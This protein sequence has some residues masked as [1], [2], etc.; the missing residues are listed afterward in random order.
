MEKATNNKL[1]VVT[2]AT[3]GIGQQIVLQLAKN[4]WNVLMINR[5]EDK[6]MALRKKIE[7]DY[8]EVEVNYLIC[9]L[10]SSAEINST[11]KAIAEKELAISALINTAGIL[12][13]EE[14]ISLTGND[15]HFQINVLA[16][17][18]LMHGLR[19]SLKRSVQQGENAIIINVSSDA[20]FMSKPLAP[21]L[22]KRPKK[23][24]VFASYAN[25]KMALTVLSTYVAQD[26]E[27]DGIDVFAINP[28]GN[29]TAMTSGKSAPF[30]VRWFN[31]LGLLP[32]PSKGA[33]YLLSPLL[34]EDFNASSGSLISVGKVKPIPKKSNTIEKI[35]ELMNLVNREIES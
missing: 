23:H 22:L 26:F 2:G 27:K 10:S 18:Q 31:S 28:G 34:D 20:I 16:A 1:A 25:S 19:T 24:G 6:S 15:Y 33:G 5:D 29:S 12:L 21:H 3:G 35:T 11:T 14:K 32:H 7:F 30:F 17:F 8:P 13:S 9:D 4:S